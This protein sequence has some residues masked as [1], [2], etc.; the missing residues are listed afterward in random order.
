MSG[1]LLSQIVIFTAPFAEPVLHVNLLFPSTE[2]QLQ[3]RHLEA[4]TRAFSN[5]HTEV[6]KRKL[7]NKLEFFFQSLYYDFP[8][9]PLGI[10]G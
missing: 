5:A 7:K 8:V 10:Y 4:G 1:F 3:P 2:K 6:I 9:L